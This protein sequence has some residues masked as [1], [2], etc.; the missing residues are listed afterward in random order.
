MFMYSMIL[1]YHKMENLTRLNALS[2]CGDLIKS[3]IFTELQFNILKKKL[4]KKDLDSNER[5]YYYKFIKPK[6]SAIYS[7]IGIGEQNIR[8]REFILESRLIKAVS[9]LKKLE[10]KHRNQKIMISGSFLFNHRY[11]DIDAFIFTKYRKEDYFSGKVHVNFLPEPALG[12]LFFSSLAQISAANFQ[13]EIKQEFKITDDDLLHTYELLVNSFLNKEDPKKELRD[14]LLKS[15][16]I[17]RGIILNPKQLYGLKEKVGSEIG[18]ISNI[19]INTLVLNHDKGVFLQKIRR[20][21]Q[22]YSQLL[23]EYA[24]SDNLKI[25]INTY[26]QVIDFGA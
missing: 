22:D 11:N 16:Y 9:L 26:Q 1:Q 24:N 12:S 15:E 10:K 3:K 5:T 20:L 14:F 7:F 2:N 23:K 4:E 19:F 21:V 25:Y 13:Y 8:G 17:S 6:L 18:L